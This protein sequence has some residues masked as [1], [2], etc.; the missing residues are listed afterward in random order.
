MRA[1]RDDLQ[2]DDPGVRDERES[3][4]KHVDYN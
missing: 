1:K 3:E 4:V 2:G